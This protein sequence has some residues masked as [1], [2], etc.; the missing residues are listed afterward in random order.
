[1]TVN[2]ASLRTGDLFASGTVS[3]PEP[4]QLGCLLE[5]DPGQAAPTSRTATRS[6]SPPGHPAPTGARIGLGEVTGRILPARMTGAPL[7]LPEDLLLLALDP[8]RGRSLN[9]AQ[10][11]PVRAGRRGAGRSGGGRA[12]R[13]RGRRPDQGDQP[14]AAGRS[15][16]GR[17]AGGAA[18]PGQAAPGRQGA[19][20]GAPRRPAGPGAVPAPAGGARRAAQGDPARPGSVPVHLLPGRGGGSRRPGPGPLRRGA[21]RRVPGPPQPV[22]RRAGL[23]DR[24][25]PRTSAEPRAPPRTPRGEAVGAGDLD[26][27]CGASARS[28]RTRRRGR[29]PPPAEPDRAAP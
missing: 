25:G 9:H 15:G 14:A 5:L 17:R 16:A 28:A 6:P 3:G 8:V 1:M 29:M 23:G 2:G 27:A 4:D 18:R 20:L 12:D 13:R 21:R 26:G 24:S 7:T 10:V 19:A 22:A 11:P